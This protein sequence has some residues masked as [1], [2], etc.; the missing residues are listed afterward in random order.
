MAIETRTPMTP[1]F[2]PDPDRKVVVCSKCLRAC[3]WQGEFY[4]DD[5]KAAETVEKTVAELS[6]FNLEHPDYWKRS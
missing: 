1:L 6:K 3:C 2:A 5:Y 4:C